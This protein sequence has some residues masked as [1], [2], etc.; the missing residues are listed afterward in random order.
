MSF[1]LINPKSSEF[2]KLTII[3]DSAGRK[4]DINLSELQAAF[5]DIKET[6]FVFQR[7]YNSEFW[8]LEILFPKRKYRPNFEEMKR[9]LEKV[10][11][12]PRTDPQ[13]NI[14]EDRKSP[15]HNSKRSKQYRRHTINHLTS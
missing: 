3:F 10:S 11:S 2:K 7:P 9:R 14:P 5:N 12:L 13:I 8:K 6:K 4:P 15:L 1:Q